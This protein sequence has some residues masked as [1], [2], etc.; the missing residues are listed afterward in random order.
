MS[1]TRSNRTTILIVEEQDRLRQ[2]VVEHLR[3]SGLDTCEALSA[4]DAIQLLEDSSSR[5]DAVFTEI[6]LPG[7]IDGMALA[8][9]IDDHRRGCPVVFTS[10]DA[11]RI[12]AAQ[13]LHPGKSVLAKP[14]SLDAVAAQIRAAVRKPERSYLPQ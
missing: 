9:W 12:A 7:F 8:E 13:C 2:V 5:I 4:D 1:T 6:D 11:E 10:D 14:Y 3:R